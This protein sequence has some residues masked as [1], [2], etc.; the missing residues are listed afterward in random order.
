MF[1]TKITMES[2]TVRIEKRSISKKCELKVGEEHIT[3]IYFKTE[4][5]NLAT[6]Y[7]KSKIKSIE[8]YE[9]E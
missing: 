3:T 5:D 8:I 1:Y 7:Y 9:G 6:E 2:G 4:R